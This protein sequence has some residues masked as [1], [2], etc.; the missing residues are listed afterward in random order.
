MDETIDAGVEEEVMGSDDQQVVENKDGGATGHEQDDTDWKAIAEVEAKKAEN[1]KN[2]LT[3]K[4]QLRNTLA[5]ILE[6][7]EEKPLTRKELEEILQS[8][9]VP[10]VSASKEDSLLSSKITEPTKRAYVKQILE[11]RI[12]RTGTS[13]DALSSDIEAA[14]AIADSH[15]KDKTISELRRAATNR[16]Q[17]PSAGSSTDVPVEQKTSNKLSAEQNRLLDTKADQLGI[18]REEF[19]KRFLDNAKKTRIL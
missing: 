11:T 18:P 19:K 9:V 7:D 15:K 5:P 10:L 6:E 8:T 17:T 13:D 3:Q 12:V 16:P 14:I 4:R 2:A 1:Y